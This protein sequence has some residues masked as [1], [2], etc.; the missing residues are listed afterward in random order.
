M[1]YLLTLMFDGT[2]YHGWQRQAN[3]ITVQQKLE[4]A[5]SAA[6]EQTPVCML[7]VLRQTFIRTLNGK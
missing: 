6:A 2:S 3:G 4:D 7:A 5:V 1:N